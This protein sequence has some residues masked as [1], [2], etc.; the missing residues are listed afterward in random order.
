MAFA[1]IDLWYGL[2]GRISRIYLPD[3]TLGWRSSQDW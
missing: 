2:N 3:A 1:G